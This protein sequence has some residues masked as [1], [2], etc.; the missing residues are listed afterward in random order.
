MHRDRIIA[1]AA[2][3]TR[4]LIV[5]CRTIARRAIRLATFTAPVGTLIEGARSI[6]YQ[7]S[8]D[9]PFIGAES[10]LINVIDCPWD[11]DGNGTVGASDL[12][13]LLVNWGPCP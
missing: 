3:T 11:L 8:A 5:N 2:G 9:Q 13:A 6:I 7:N 12:L 10:F 4:K 1:H